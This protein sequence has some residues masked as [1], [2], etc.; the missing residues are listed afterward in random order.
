M[1]EAIADKSLNMDLT[2]IYYAR[3]QNEAIMSQRFDELSEKAS[4]FRIIYVFSDEHVFKCERGFVTK[5]II[6]KYAPFTKYSLFVSG[7]NTLYNRLIPQISELK[8]ENKY[9]RF[10][11]NGQIINPETL[12]D[13]PQDAIGKTFLC[14]VIKDGELLATVPCSS[15]ESLLD[16]I[17]TLVGSEGY[18]ASVL[19]EQGYITQ[20]DMQLRTFTPAGTQPTPVLAIKQAAAIVAQLDDAKGRFG[21][22]YQDNGGVFRAG[23][24]VE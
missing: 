23:W 16:C 17:P 10:G 13:F 8:L 22:C 20:Y 12:P 9:I 24:V 18:A 19:V 3:K 6:E 15:T 21:L 11:L 4:N 2:L 7:S 1:A 14:K 5:S